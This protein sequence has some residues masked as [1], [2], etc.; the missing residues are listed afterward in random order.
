MTLLI[1]MVSH[2]N[3]YKMQQCR[4]LMDLKTTR[5]FAKVMSAVFRL[6]HWSVQ[7]R[8]ALIG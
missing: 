7:H 3:Y 1:L 2:S 4:G 5:N 8:I 6:S